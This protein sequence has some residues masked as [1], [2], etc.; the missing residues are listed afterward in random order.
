[1]KVTV[2]SKLLMFLFG[3]GLFPSYVTAPPSLWW[4]WFRHPRGR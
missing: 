1:M 2:R 3:W 4:Q